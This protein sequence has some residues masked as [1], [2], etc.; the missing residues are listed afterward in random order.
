MNIGL[1]GGT[2]DPIHRGHLKVARAATER[3]KL[4]EVWFV[5]A[6]IP[7]HK[8][9]APVTSYFHRYS[10]VSLALAG[11]AD[12]LPSLLEAP[13]A[14]A[15]VERRPSY[16]IDTVRR[17]KAGLR[18]GDR[19]YFLIGIDAFQDIAKWYEAEALLKECEFI[20]AA[21]PGYS[22][23]EVA[24]S[25]P[26]K[27]RPK[28]HDAVLWQETPPLRQARGRRYHQKRAVERGT[29][30]NQRTAGLL[31]LT[32]VRLHLLP[33]THEDVSA[34]QIRAAMRNRKGLNKLVPDAVAEYI[35]KEGLY[36]GTAGRKPK[37]K[38]RR[39]GAEVKRPTQAK[40]A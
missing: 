23:D 20:V 13:D 12:F 36:R 7:P 14:E 2:F 33:E 16:S 15:H 4:K 22:L 34:T 38:I 40:P 25:L 6:D 18:K 21:R 28:N 1:F 9:T 29:P 11:E 19:L 27:L 5:P 17:V 37:Q 3:F 8:Q 31:Q 26:Q 24:S 32:G 35:R 10:M 39:G 30:R